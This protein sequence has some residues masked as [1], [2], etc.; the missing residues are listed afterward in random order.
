MDGSCEYG[1]EPS[2]S[3]KCG[4]S[5]SNCINGSFLRRAQLHGVSCNFDLLI[6]FPN[7]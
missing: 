4:K 6:S 3:I 1:N 7:I 5:L 2:S